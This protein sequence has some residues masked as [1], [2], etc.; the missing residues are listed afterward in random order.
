MVLDRS[1]IDDTWGVGVPI[2]T[3]WL[4]AVNVT[5]NI[6]DRNVRLENKYFMG[7]VL[8][9][10]IRRDEIH[11]YFSLWISLLAKIRNE[12][13]KVKYEGSEYII[14]SMP[15]AGIIKWTRGL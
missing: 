8:G 6:P 10:V 11:N 4:L 9:M 5:S 3:P 2:P 7:L 15:R 14:P 13:S 1:R 12:Y